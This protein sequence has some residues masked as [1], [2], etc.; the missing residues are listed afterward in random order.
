MFDVADEW[1]KLK[2]EKVRSW[3]F[4]RSFGLSN[5]S[6]KS[7]VVCRKRRVIQVLHMKNWIRTLES[8]TIHLSLEL[9]LYFIAKSE[10]FEWVQKRIYQLVQYSLNY[11][12]RFGSPRLKKKREKCMKNRFSPW[13]RHGDIPNLIMLYKTILLVDFKCSFWFISTM[14]PFHTVKSSPQSCPPSPDNISVNCGSYGLKLNFIWL[15]CYEDEVFKRWNC[16]V[17]DFK[18]L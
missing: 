13:S 6:S 9:A 3:A 4:E 15:N 18:V 17:Q 2:F 12:H 16:C 1:E 14:D 7:K 11:V 5:W 8:W 10:L